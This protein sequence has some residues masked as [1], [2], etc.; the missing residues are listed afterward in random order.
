MRKA[1]ID[2]LGYIDTGGR[3]HGVD[4]SLFNG[5][6]P[7]YHALP[8]PRA[9]T[10]MLHYAERHRSATAREAETQPRTQISNKGITTNSFRRRDM[11]GH[12]LMHV[13]YPSKPPFSLS[14]PAPDAVLC[15]FSLNSRYKQKKVSIISVLIVMQDATKFA[16][17]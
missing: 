6:T 1:C 13:T 5:V 3:P 10:E 17:S 14:L 4:S 7:E 16:Y 9:N 8:H 15:G 11:Q 12:S 2:I